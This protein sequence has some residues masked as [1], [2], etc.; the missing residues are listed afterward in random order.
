MQS[1]TRQRI[2][3]FGEQIVQQVDHL[4]K[5]T[6]STTLMFAPFLITLVI[7]ATATLFFREYANEPKLE[8]VFKSWS[9]QDSLRTVAHQD[10]ALLV[11]VQGSRVTWSTFGSIHLLSCFAA[12]LTGVWIFRKNWMRYSFS[13]QLG[14]I[15]FTSAT[16]DLAFWIF[17]GEGR[18]KQLGIGLLNLT[19]G[20]TTRSLLNMTFYLDA[21]GL[22]TAGF[23]A[24]SS[25]A[26]LMLPAKGSRLDA[27]ELLHRAQHQRLILYASAVVLVTG[28]LHVSTLFHWSQECIP[29]SFVTLRSEMHTLVTSFVNSRAIFYSLV[30]GGIYLPGA[31][32]LQN[33]LQKLK[34]ETTDEAPDKEVERELA[35]NYKDLIPRIIAVLAPLLAGPAFEL[36]KAVLGA[37]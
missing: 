18:I 4:Q 10:T 25:C 33:E 2:K 5:F 1:K 31:L 6:V 8:E 12:F 14:L 9:L 26:L 7:F 24:V 16:I 22:A 27:S 19:V 23:L 28:V 21:I 20:V 29:T 11:R 34:R 13:Q 3:H 36:F 30:L 15:V 35:T 32:F 17:L 37:T